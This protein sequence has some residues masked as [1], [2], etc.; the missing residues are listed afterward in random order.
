MPRLLLAGAG[1]AHMAVMAAIPELVAKGHHVTAIGPGERHYYSGMG[2]GML[3]GTYQP[4]EISFPVRDMVESRGGVFIQDT[5][6]AIDPARHVVIL[7][8]GHEE[9]YDVLSC[10]LGSFVPRDL[11]TKDSAG[12]TDRLNWQEG[13]DTSRPVFPAKPIEQLWQA[14][15]HILGLA[16]DRPVRVGVCGGGPA[17]LEIAGNAWA[18]GRENGGKGCV[19]QL[20]VGGRLLRTMPEKVRRLAKKALRKRGIE[21]IEGSYVRSVQSEVVLL[22]NEQRHAQDV[23]FLALGV[24]PSPVFRAS[25][26]EVSE[27][28]GLL[29]DQCLQSLSHPDIFGGGDC[30]TF[31]PR[32]LDKVGVYA[33]RQNPVLLHNLQAQLEGRSL[34]AFDPGGTYLL[35]FNIGGGQGILHKSGVAFGG[36]TAFWIKDYI[37]RKFI[38][39]YLPNV[40]SGTN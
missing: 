36:R 4:E 12:V 6:A 15:R 34:K 8:S 10:N 28:G 27:D 23:V 38:K 19:V 1:H 37:D 2:P 21:V 9:P 26:L 20:F 40:P 39:K 7:K 25:G 29:V 32:P 33:V 3:G 31:A 22:E 13:D 11:T 24:R 14:R 30:I 5:V 35:I 18:A 17:A 16:R